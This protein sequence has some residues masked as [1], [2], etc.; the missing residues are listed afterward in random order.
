MGRAFGI[1]IRQIA[2]LL[3]IIHESTTQTQ[4]CLE[5]TFQESLN[6]QLYLEFHL[7]PTWDWLLTVMDATEA[8]LRF[9]ASLTQNADPTHPAHPLHS[10]ANVNLSGGGMQYA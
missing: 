7:K 1:V 10:A 6:L 9:G 4:P 2:D 5:V 3:T 8:Q